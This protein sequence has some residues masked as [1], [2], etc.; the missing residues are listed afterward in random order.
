MSTDG[1]AQGDRHA[2][3][4]SEQFPKRKIA[5]GAT[6]VLVVVGTYWGLHQTGAL[7]VLGDQQ[8]LQDM[9]DRLGFWGPLAII[10]LM[11]AAIVMSPIPS[12]P[13]GLAAGAAYG[14]LWGALYVVIGSTGGAVI[15]FA[16]ARWFGY[17]AV[18]RWLKGRLSFL[19]GR[20]SQTTL[21]AIVFSSRLVPFISF[22][23]VSY[24]AGLTPLA[25]WRF[26][27]ATLA[28]IVPISFAIAYFGESLV[29][30]NA[31]WAA[32]AAVLVGGITLVPLVVQWA[33]ARRA[34]EPSTGGR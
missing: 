23:A 16:I 9:I 28:G 15:A 11:A 6:A 7:A 14:P 3:G 25:F 24:A 26:A 29:S 13:I 2:A 12:A 27:V 4:S 10:V 19:E 21:M 31:R 32:V 22:D 8:G 5:I 17:G 20:H 1:R 30:A 33:R 34:K 18:R